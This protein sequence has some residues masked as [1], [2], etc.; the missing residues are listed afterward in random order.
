M[1][2]CEPMVFMY[3]LLLRRGLIDEAFW[4][5]KEI[6]LE[7]AG[8]GELGNQQVAVF[9]IVLADGGAT[10]VLQTAGPVLQVEEGLIE[11]LVHLQNAGVRRQ[12]TQSHKQVRMDVL[13][14][15]AGS[16]GNTEPQ[17]T[18]GISVTTSC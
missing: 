14:P 15:D 8:N 4:L 16:S 13:N 17:Q 18:G 2:K 1:E 5:Q 9:A 11:G 12:T 10:Q 3:A 6:T 7:E